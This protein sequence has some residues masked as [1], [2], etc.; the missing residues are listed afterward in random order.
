MQSIKEENTKLG[1]YLERIE[2]TLTSKNVLAKGTK[3]LLATKN[4]EIDKQ[5]GRC[6]TL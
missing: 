3:I 5:G 4:Q 1:N 6:N 2:T